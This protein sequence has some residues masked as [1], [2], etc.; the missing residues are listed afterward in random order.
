MSEPTFFAAARTFSAAEI[1]DFTGA[2]ARA[3]DPVD[4]RISGIAALDQAGPRDIAFFG[5][6]RCSGR[7]PDLRAGICL[8]TAE[9]VSQ[10]PSRVVALITSDP[11]PAFVAVAQKLFPDAM[12]PSFLFGEDQT[13]AGAF[14]HPTA[15]ME[16]E[17][18]IGSGAVIGPGAEIGT[19]TVIGPGAAVGPGVRIGRYCSIGAGASV[20]NALIG[21]HVTLHAG[22]RIGQDGF[23]YIPAAA[24]Y[25]KV[26]QV[27]RVILQDRVEVGANTT[28]DRGS[29]RDTV[30]GEGTKIDNLVQ[31]GHNVFIGR[32]CIIVAQSGLSGSVT[33]EDSV[34][35]GGQVGIADHLTIGE[36][37]Q[38][39]A[40]S[41]VMHDVPAGER[42]LGTPAMPARELM[43][44]VSLQTAGSRSPRHPAQP[45][46]MTDEE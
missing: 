45:N 16:A 23:G 1:C 18:R 34:V 22:C 5:D 44:Q 26:P 32:H 38:V 29:D 40:K 9:L 8:V 25:R 19:Q 36:G 46:E 37:A 28:I 2:V 33:L 41:G 27:G 4:H 42:W 30:I 14:V 20:T 12:R 35:L 10:V 24:G 7:L 17:V 6:V 11:Y 43:Q 21:D 39:G 3:G 15:R 31:I 13:P